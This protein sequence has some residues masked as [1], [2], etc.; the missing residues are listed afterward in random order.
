LIR[1]L[2][3]LEIIDELNPIAEKIKKEELYFLL[4]EN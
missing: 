3:N 4:P 1:Q 2:S